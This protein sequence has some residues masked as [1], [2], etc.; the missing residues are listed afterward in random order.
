MGDHEIDFQAECERLTQRLRQQDKITAALMKRVELSM[1]KQDDSFSLFQA[2]AAL[3]SEVRDRT[4][5]L[6]S[7]L[8]KLE[9]TN[10]ELVLARDKANNANLAKS[11]FLANISHEIRTPM[12][13]VLGMTELL[14][15]TEMNLTQKRFARTIQRSASSLLR[16]IN[17][18]LD[19]S[20][21]E[22]GKF[23]LDSVAF[24]LLEHVEDVTELMGEPAQA[25]GLELL[26]S[27]PSDL[28]S[29]YLGDPLRIRQ[30]LVNLVGNAIK[31]T[32][33]GQV[34]IS[35]ASTLGDDSRHAEL[36]IEVSDTGIGIPLEAQQKIFQS[37][38]QADGSTTRTYGGTGLGLSIS[39][40]LVHLMGGEMGVNSTP[41]E[42]A[43]F[44]FSLTLPLESSNGTNRVRSLGE[45]NRARILVVDDNAT[46]L[47]ILKHQLEGWG[48]H[49]ELVQGGAEAMEL[50]HSDQLGHFDLAILDYHMPGVTGLE[51]VREMRDKPAYGGCTGSYVELGIS[52][53][54]RAGKGPRGRSE[55]RT[56]VLDQA[57]QVF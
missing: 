31:F 35:V 52:E 14:L 29:V 21:M 47:E 22:A 24:D 10:R 56:F 42:G 49:V 28:P 27:F 11:E 17:D 55:G 44:W 1:D 5:S 34:L 4:A 30:I 2:A 51:L 54:D 46:N 32:S 6:E 19:Y 43:T 57:D 26:C 45:L 12:N 41:G 39:S 38:A 23:E 3:E 8:H 36:R 50:L 33:E 18:L 7:V 37:F 16:I 48:S 15:G 25:S 40:Q 53:F 20:K 9:T 13:G